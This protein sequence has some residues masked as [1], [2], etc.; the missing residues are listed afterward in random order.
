[1]GRAPRAAAKSRQE[2]PT[3]ADGHARQPHDA[4]V[5]SEELQRRL[6]LPRRRAQDLMWPRCTDHLQQPCAWYRG[7]SS[8]AHTVSTVCPC[9]VCGHV[10]MCPS[11]TCVHVESPVK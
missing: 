1:M 11:S 10:C 4:E 3:G 8:Y 6:E 9:V 5:H 2:N 7:T